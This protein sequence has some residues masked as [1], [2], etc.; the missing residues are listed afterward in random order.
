MSDKPNSTGKIITAIVAFIA[1]N[2]IIVS[3]VIYLHI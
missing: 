3:M 2:I 1:L